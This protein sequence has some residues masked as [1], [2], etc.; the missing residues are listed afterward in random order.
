M[1]IL[2]LTDLHSSGEV[3]IVTIKKLI[4]KERIDL[5]LIAGDITS[6]GKL[7]LVR[8]ILEK[9][10]QVGK[11]VLYVPGNMDSRGTENI[12]LSNVSSI[13][14]KSVIIDGIGFIGVG[15]SNETPFSTP[16]ILTEEEIE[17]LLLQ[18]LNSLPEN[19]PIFLMSHPPPKDSAADKIHN[20][21]HVGSTAVRS[22][23]E[24]YQPLV[25]FCGHIHESKSI[26]FIGPTLC[27]N[28]G[29]TYHG[30]ATI[31]KIKKEDNDFI[32]TA[33]LLEI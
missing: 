14:G 16:F 4:A 22:F 3:N 8:K 9:F 25:V 29:A 11:P 28:P 27:V 7:D 33:R 19:I 2:G 5:I 24:K 6:W 21:K 1:R 23:I 18:G 26:S 13:Y 31:I 30:Q 32:A 17:E 20:G 10:N 15:G 12:Q